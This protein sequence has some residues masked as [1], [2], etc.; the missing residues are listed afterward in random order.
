MMSLPSYFSYHKHGI[1]VRFVGE[2]DAEFILSL[3]T[4]PELNRFIHATSSDIENQRQ[5]IRDYKKR[6]MDGVEYYFIY[7]KDGPPFCVNRIYGINGDEGTTGSWICALKTNPVDVLTT[8]IVL[9]Y[10][11]FDEIKLRRVLFDTRKDNLSALK[12]NRALGGVCIDETDKDYFFQ[13]IPSKYHAVRNDLI[14][15]WHIKQ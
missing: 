9:Y 3:R 14:R 12:V 4:N 8:S 13:L 6:E 7:S 11:V 15:V 10:I 2:D 1:D 5:W